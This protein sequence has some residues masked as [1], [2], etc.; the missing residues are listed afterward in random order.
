M[1]LE[2]FK[3]III[4][5]INTIFYYLVFISLI[6]F[7]VDYKIAIL[8][9]T[10]FATIFSFINFGKYVFNNQ[11]KSLIIKFIL[12][13]IFIYFLNIYLVKIIHEIY[14][15]NL[16]LSGFIAIIPLTILSYIINKFYVFK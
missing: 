4:G 3:F 7:S 2:L 10:V 15:L 14:I 12:N 11:K 9:S 1:K 8:G 6:F 13:T 16:Y 5:S